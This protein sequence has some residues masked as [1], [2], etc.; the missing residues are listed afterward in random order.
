MAGFMNRIK[1]YRQSGELPWSVRCLKYF[2]KG[3]FYQP[4]KAIK[5]FIPYFKGRYPAAQYFAQVFGPAMLKETL[6]VCRKLDIQPFLNYGTLLGYLREEAI[7][8]TDNDIDL[9]LMAKDY[10]KLNQLKTEMATI[11]YEVRDQ[12]DQHFE[13]S[14]VKRAFGCLFIDFW[15]HYPNNSG[16]KVYSGSMMAF[17]QDIVCIHPYPKEVYDD[18]KEVDFLGSR[19]CIPT[20]YED[21][22]VWTYGKDWQKPMS[23]KDA[24]LPYLE[25]QKIMHPN[26]IHVSVADFQKGNFL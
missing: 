13:I 2:F 7:I 20:R 17:D 6:A 16:D 15:A 8:E 23:Q 25:K 12:K 11:G 5:Y 21:Y 24:E 1:Y 19:V 14:F 3:L 10:E 18:F 22:I 26:V 4:G 9:G